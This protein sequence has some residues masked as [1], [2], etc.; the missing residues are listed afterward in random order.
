MEDR[1]CKQRERE[2][3]RERVRE[4]AGEKFIIEKIPKMKV[5]LAI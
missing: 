1:R 2:R 3:E 5:F 4:G